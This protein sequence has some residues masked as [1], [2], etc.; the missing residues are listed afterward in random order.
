MGDETIGEVYHLG[1]RI[2]VRW[3]WGEPSWTCTLWYGPEAP[4]SR[5]RA[6]ITG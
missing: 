1:W 2:H 3:A 5:S 4:R 6:L